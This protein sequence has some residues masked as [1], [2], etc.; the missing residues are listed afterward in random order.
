MMQTVTEK[1]QIIPVKQGTEPI[2]WHM[3]HGGSSGGPGDYPVVHVV[4]ETAADFEI[5]IV[6]PGSIRFSSDPIWVQRGTQ[7]PTQHVIDGI[8]D[9]RGQNTTTLK[10]HDGNKNA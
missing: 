7:K 9:I 2:A 4:R 1:I 6:N 3:S 10:F 5:N 8:S